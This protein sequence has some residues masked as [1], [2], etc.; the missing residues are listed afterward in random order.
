MAF[1]RDVNIDWKHGV[2]ALAE[3]AREGASECGEKFVVV[4]KCGMLSHE[5]RTRE[6]R[7]SGPHA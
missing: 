3:P 5:L 4:C 2:R 6:R 7:V 1:G